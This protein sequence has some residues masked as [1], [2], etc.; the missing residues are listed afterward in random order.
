MRGGRGQVLVLRGDA[1]IGK[2]SLLDHQIR[3]ASEFIVLRA[4]GVE[5]EMEIPFAALHQLC[6][7]SLDR[8][9]ELPTPQRDAISTAFGLASGP[10]P[11][12][13]LIGLAVLTLLS[14]ISDDGPLLCVIDDAQWLDQESA[15]ALAFVARRMLAEPV[16]LVFATRHVAGAFAA[17]P[18]L[19]V[20]ALTNTNARTLLNEVLHVALD[21]RVRDRILADAR[22]NPLA[23]VEWPRDLRLPELASGFGMPSGTVTWR[24][25]EHFRRRVAELP[26]AAQRYLT[27]AAAEPTGDPVIVWRAANALG[28][29]PHDAAPAIEAGLVEIGVRV[30][31][32][33]PLVRSVAY[34]AAPLEARRSAHRE[35]ARATDGESDPD[36]RTWHRA[37]GSSGPDEEI[38]AALEGLAV[39]TRARGGLAATAALLE[40]SVALSVDPSTRARRLVAAA[41]AQLEAGLFETA[42]GLLASAEDSALDD[43]GRAMLEL[44]WGRHATYGGDLREAPGRLLT[45][46]KRFEA[47]DPEFAV[48]VHVQVMSAAAIVGGF[49]HG[50]TL[51]EASEAALACPLSSTPTIKEWLM[52]GLARFTI[53][54]PAAAAP[55]LRRALAA[56]N[57]NSDEMQAWQTRGY[58]VGAALMM[59]DFEEFRRLTTQ[60]LMEMR[61]L[62]VLSML[63]SALNS[64]AHGCALAGDL[65]GAAAALAE[66]A[67]IIDETGS[68]L[69][70]TSVAALRAG[71]RG[72]DGAAHMIETQRAEASEAYLD[73][74]LASALWGSATLCNGRAQY[75]QGLAAAMEAMQREWRQGSIYFHELIESAVRV[76]RRD[77]A[78]ETLEQ[79]REAT[80]ASGSDWAA[81]VHLRSAA[82]LSS[83]TEAETFYREALLRL[84]RTSVRSELARAHLLYGEWLRRENR[85]VDARA[86]LRAAFD[87][88][89]AMGARGFAERARHELVATGESV[90]RRTTDSFDDLTPQEANIARLAADGRTNP[91]IGTH[92]FI[93]PRT[94]EYHLGKIFSKLGVS[95]RREL[96]VALPRNGA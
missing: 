6:A 17:F 1:G 33:H 46:A 24:V 77:V 32:R 83:G 64:V 94:V 55:A 61:E 73:V 35:L 80:D 42:A 4:V 60:N 71:L 23:L 27:V 81:G 79:L 74:N 53:E 36:R 70:F 34:N 21:D 59:W 75:E 72:D 40:R 39:R 54:G 56:P 5:S 50:P 51:R 52:L 58:K 84:G 9:N 82:L 92:L 62:G 47:L 89:T 16:G 10:S 31:F 38:A 91:E 67:Q 11:D 13:L 66:A 45:A 44:L 26:E 3:A 85:R 2:S 30:A 76:G 22:G 88:F 68:G 29:G 19:R 28:I 18:E 12:R 95:S 57:D 7:S 93:S 86:E 20:D 63:P 8:L 65:D 87:L 25:E 37:L 69:F 15:Q 43:P 49:G 41:A 90:H 14:T 96:R 48:F 78:E